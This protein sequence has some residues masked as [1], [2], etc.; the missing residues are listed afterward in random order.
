MLCVYSIVI[1]ALIHRT[2]VRENYELKN[3]FFFFT[4]GIS[5]I[6]CTCSTITRRK[7]SVIIDCITRRSGFTRLPSNLLRYHHNRKIRRLYQYLPR[8]MNNLFQAMYNFLTY[9]IKKIISSW[10]TPVINEA[11]GLMETK[12]GVRSLDAPRAMV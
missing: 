12:Y 3:I 5:L 9:L 1:I 6:K 8:N 10:Y 7:T 4:K 2:S 11:R